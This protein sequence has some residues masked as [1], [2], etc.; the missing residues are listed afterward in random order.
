[1]RRINIKCYDC[2]QEK[3]EK[4]KAGRL[5]VQ[6]AKR[7]YQREY[8]SRKRSNKP[9]DLNVRPVRPYPVI[10]DVNRVN[11]PCPNC[12]LQARYISMLENQLARLKGINAGGRLQEQTKT[13]DSL[14][15][16]KQRQTKTSS[17][18]MYELRMVMSDNYWHGM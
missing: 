6:Q 14:P 11:P 4:A 1:M 8:M 16:S 12:E 5:W 15:F 18:G 2:A 3:W 13:S 9:L 17:A 7:V 10:P